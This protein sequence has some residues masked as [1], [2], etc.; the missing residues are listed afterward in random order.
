MKNTSWS[1]DKVVSVINEFNDAIENLREKAS[2]FKHFDFV[3][4]CLLYL[5]Q[6]KMTDA[7]EIANDKIGSSMLAYFN[8]IT[9]SGNVTIN[10][11]G[12]QETV[13]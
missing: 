10:T 4:S 9:K 7:W 12:K 1:K 11:D 13:M 2:D 8:K 6:A 5:K 3:K